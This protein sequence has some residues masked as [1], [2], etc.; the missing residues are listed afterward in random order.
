[1][2]RARDSY[3]VTEWMHPRESIPTNMGPM[4]AEL[5]CHQEVVRFKDK[6]S[7]A[8]LQVNNEGM[9]A[10]FADDDGYRRVSNDDPKE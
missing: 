6:W 9:I 2:S 4:E 3:Q 7:E 8:W 10:V 5:W 1:M